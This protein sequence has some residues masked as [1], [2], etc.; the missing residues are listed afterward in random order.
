MGIFSKAERGLIEK[1]MSKKVMNV[2]KWESLTGKFTLDWDLVKEYNIVS[3][4]PALSVQTNNLQMVSG[5]ILLGAALYQIVTRDDRYAKKNSMEFVVTDGARYK[6]D[7]GSIADAV[8]NNMDQNPYN[9]YPCEPNWIYSLCNSV[10]ISGIVA[11]DKVLGND[12]GDRLKGRFEAALAS[13]FSNADGTILP[14][15][16]ELTGFTIP[17]LAGAI[18]DVAPSIFCGPYLPHVAH[19]HWALMKQENLRWRDDGHL[20]LTNLVSADNLDP[21]N[22]RSGRGYVRIA[23]ASVATEFGD[24]KIRD[25][26]M[27]QTDEE[28]FP[29][30]ETRTGALKN[31]GLSTLGQI[32]T[33][34]SRLGAHGD[35]NSLLKDGPAEHC[36]R[37][38]ILDEVPF[39]DV[40][41]G[42]AYSHDG[43]LVEL[44]LY[45]GKTAG[46]FTLGFKNMKAGRVYRLGSQAAVANQK[47]EAQLSFLVDGRT[48][49]SLEPV[50]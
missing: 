32:N 31:K 19:R 21:G 26:L 10:G 35:W 38:P 20:E 12:Y 48:A 27:R 41:V 2:W 34:R 43:E 13:E 1:S 6:Y 4:I 36:F 24:Y 30:Y 40:L 5:C 33:L 25:E 50:D 18:S 49:V 14:I 15:R 8:F 7:L 16:S 42:K 29:V 17:G 44:V 9:L 28:Q 47:G 3:G 45:N 39:P 46:K 11:S 37:A 22:Y 23:L